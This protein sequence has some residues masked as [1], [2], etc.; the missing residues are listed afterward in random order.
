MYILYLNFI[1]LVKFVR[2]PYELCYE[3]GCG[4]HCKKG[5]P[6]FRVLYENQEDFRIACG[7]GKH[8]QGK[9]SCLNNESDPV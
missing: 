7:C 1:L 9:W 3:P 5:N 2:K 8:T 4:N 6:T